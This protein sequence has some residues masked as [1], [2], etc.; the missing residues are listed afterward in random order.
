MSDVGL[1]PPRPRPGGSSRVR[2]FAAGFL[3]AA[4]LTLTATPSFAQRTIRIATEGADPPFNYVDGNE[5][6][7]F[8][9]DLA[10]VLCAAMK[11]TCTFVIQDWDT[12]IDALLEKRF[13]AI[14]SS[15]PITQERRQRISFSKRYYVIPSAFIA[16]KDTEVRDTSPAALAGKSIGTNAQSEHASLLDDLYKGSVAKGYDKLEEANLDLLTGRLD[17]V[18]GDKL[19]LSRFLESREGAVCCKFVADVPVNPIYNGEGMGVGLRKQDKDLKE[20]FNGAIDKVI[21]D[22]TYD[23]VRSKYFSFD[24]K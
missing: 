21:A 11:A 16:R 19:A 12:M 7:G 20:L 3:F 23:R 15:M 18:L 4:L 5:P 24:I 14:M 22:G 8:E 2:R 13:D 9:V 6:Q 17:L 1:G 10:K